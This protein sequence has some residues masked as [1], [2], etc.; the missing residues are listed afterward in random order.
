MNKI[1]FSSNRK[2]QDRQTHYPEETMNPSN[3]RISDNSVIDITD[4]Y[5]KINADNNLDVNAHL[6][7]S[8]INNL[9]K[10]KRTENF[11]NYQ[12][13]DFY[14]WKVGTKYKKQ[15]K[16]SKEQV[17][18]LNKLWFPYSTFCRIEFCLIAIIK[19]YIHLFDG[20]QKIYN[21]EGTNTEE[22]FSQVT[23][24]I[25]RKEFKYKAG[26]PNYKFN[27]EIRNIELYNLIFKHCE[28]TVREYYAH[29]RKRN[30]EIFYENEE[31]QSEIE[32][33]IISKVKMLLPSLIANIEVPDE[34]TEI[35]LNAQNTTRWRIKL[36]ELISTFTGDAEKFG[37][38][39]I[40][41]G[42][43]NKKNPA[44]KN[45][46][47]EAAKFISKHDRKT[48]LN[49]Y[50]HYL[51]Q[52]LL[53]QKFENKQI[54]KSILKSF[55]RTKEQLQDFNNIANDLVSDRNID[56]ALENVAKIF[57]IKRKEVKLNTILINEVRERHSGTVE[58][59]NVYLQDE[60]NVDTH[61]TESRE[62]RKEIH[63]IHEEYSDMRMFAS[64]QDLKFSQNQQEILELFAR[65]NFT[66]SISSVEAYAKS[67]NLL[68]NNLIESLND[69]CYELI[70]DVLIELTEEFYTINQDYF[71]KIKAI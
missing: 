41:V 57:E 32:T 50:L 24:I 17:T 61:A 42:I 28:N 16:L 36:K 39:V 2:K 58:L 14:Y 56:K 38:L 45:I 44:A 21:L 64:T 1:F 43:Q 55:F 49:L 59:L 23:D 12:I 69:I 31:L 29:K 63:E 54:P 68:S 47:F 48:A 22:R 46:F 65:N 33:K 20:L 67:K 19:L 66:L 4:Q 62:V 18:L 60:T 6:T 53:S 30:V 3:S 10:N 71:K 15:L 11:S 27:Y 25:L 26:S 8:L 34:A 9:D 37:N 35:E 5:R 70:D 52:D 7:A 51:N 13:N 40:L